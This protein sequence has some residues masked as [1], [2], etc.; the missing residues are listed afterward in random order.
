MGA[1]FTWAHG[2]CA[3]AGRQHGKDSFVAASVRWA[4][5]MNTR[6]LVPSRVFPIEPAG[7]QPFPF[8]AEQASLVHL[9]E[10]AR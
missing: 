6:R 4:L 9:D 2:E 8:D 1:S 10:N 3:V 7:I 5:R